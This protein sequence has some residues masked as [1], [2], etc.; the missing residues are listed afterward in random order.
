MYDGA[1]RNSASKASWKACRPWLLTV[2][3]IQAA[4]LICAG[5]IL[6]HVTPP[7]EEE[8]VATTTNRAIL[9]SLIDPPILLEI[10][11][12]QQEVATGD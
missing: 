12:G 8:T 5:L 10:E 2:Q 3:A 1:V 6:N 11:F 7:P 9:E 4:G